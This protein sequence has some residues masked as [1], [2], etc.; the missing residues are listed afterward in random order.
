[1]ALTRPD[2]GGSEPML[3][4]QAIDVDLQG[5]E[6]FATLLR[7]EVDGNLRPYSD[8]IIREHS[9]GVAFG[10]R[11]PSSEVQAA[12]TAYHDCL[13]KA[14]EALHSYV[15]TSEVLLTAAQKVAELYTNADQ[16]STARMNDIDAALTAAN[17]EVMV[18]DA[19]RTAA[20]A[21]LAVEEARH[22]TERELH[23]GGR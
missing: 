22:E 23:R 20:T 14:Y 7:G 1:M 9:D 15:H 11:S 10:A 5:L 21:A 17:T 12:R 6:D 19:A 13:T 2:E 18:A 16:L 3:D 4:L 8:E